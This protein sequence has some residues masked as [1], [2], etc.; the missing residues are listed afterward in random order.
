M[1]CDLKNVIF[2]P[3]TLNWKWGGCSHNVKFGEKVA[4]LWLQTETATTNIK[5]LIKSHNE[6][7]GHRV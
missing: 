1:C 5:Q 4:K 6:K 3:G 7:A 2:V